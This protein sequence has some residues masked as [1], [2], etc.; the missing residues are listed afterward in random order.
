MPRG[1]NFHSTTTHV[2]YH[3]STTAD[4]WARPISP[5]PLSPHAMGQVKRWL[6]K[7]REKEATLQ[8]QKSKRLKQ[9]NTQRTLR[10]T[11]ESHQAANAPLAS[12]SP[13]VRNPENDAPSKTVSR[14]KSYGNEEEWRCQFAPTASEVPP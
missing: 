3:P 5:E 6:E 12:T 9:N 14:P 2:K 1:S 10:S 8:E 7:K 4:E 11:F 13:R